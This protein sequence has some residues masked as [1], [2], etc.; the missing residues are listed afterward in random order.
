M[1]KIS[2][3]AC[4]ALVAG[5]LVSCSSEAGTVDYNDVRT[6]TN[7]NNYVVSGS[8]AE[9]VYTE[10]GTYDADNKQTDGSK[11]TVTS[12]V[13]FKAAEATVAYTVDS[14]D[15]TN[16]QSYSV[17]YDASEGWSSRVEET[18][19]FSGTSWSTP[20]KTEVAKGTGDPDTNIPRDTFSFYS[21]DGVFYV[22]G[23]GKAYSFEADE[24]AIQAGEDFTVSVTFDTDNRTSDDSDY[25]TTGKLE[26]GR[27]TS[28]NKTSITYNLTFSAK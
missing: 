28:V 13:Y 26:A 18:S 3:I 27:A 23:Y 25:D 22:D 12:T 6:T 2:I 5:L 16:Y 19:S 8:I 11:S 21:V 4:A 20:S 14:V 1:K 15:E 10:S 24:D 9:T 7:V 17:K